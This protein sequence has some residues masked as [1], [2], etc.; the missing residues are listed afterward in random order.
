MEQAK[1]NTLRLFVSSAVENK[2]EL[3]EVDRYNLNII[4]KGLE[5]VAISVRNQGPPLE[6]TLI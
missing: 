5:W 3:D 4:N 2:D 6:A 1:T